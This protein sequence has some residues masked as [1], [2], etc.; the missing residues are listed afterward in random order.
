MALAGHGLLSDKCV[1][2][3]RL[4]GSPDKKKMIAI[5]VAYSFQECNRVPV[6]KYDY[7]LDYIFTERGI[8]SSKY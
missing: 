7:K 3:S 6:N 2:T 4:V 8:I 1:N 5:G